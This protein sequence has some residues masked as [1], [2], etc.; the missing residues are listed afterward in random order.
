MTEHQARVMD[1]RIDAVTL[2]LAQAWLL[3]KVGSVADL[4]AT[5]QARLRSIAEWAVS[6]VVDGK[7]E[8]RAG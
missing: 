2:A 8:R 6:A 7:Q 5:E 4:P 1:K 3:S